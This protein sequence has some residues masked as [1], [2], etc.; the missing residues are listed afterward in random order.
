MSDLDLEEECREA[1][2][3]IQQPRGHWFGD[4]FRKVEVALDTK[5]YKTANGE[6][7]SGF[8]SRT[9]E[10]NLCLLGEDE[11]NFSQIVAVVNL[12][13]HKNNPAQSF[14][15]RI[16]CGGEFCE[17]VK[18]LYPFVDC[19]LETALAAVV[20][21]ITSWH[22]LV[23]WLLPQR[24]PQRRSSGRAFR[25]VA[26]T[27][28]PPNPNAIPPRF[29]VTGYKR[30]FCAACNAFVAPTN[31]DAHCPCHARMLS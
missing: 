29:T 10:A 8:R 7:A 27:I 26:F 16:R 14:K 4:K 11:V 25:D 24:A 9:R 5:I 13:R 31:F 19:G 21:G 18:K 22:S 3:A 6:I 15:I 1:F 17:V 23:S 28:A 30:H 12:L 2:R 20:V